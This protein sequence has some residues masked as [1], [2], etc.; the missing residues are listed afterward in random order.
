MQNIKQHLNKIYCMDSLEF[1]KTLPD[2]CVDLVLTDPPYNISQ[3]SGG[4]RE[5]D[6]GEWDKDK[7]NRLVFNAIKEIDRICNGTIIIF[8]GN[9]Q[10]SYI[11]NFLESKDYITKCLV[12]LKPNPSVIN[13]QHSFVAGQELIV[14]AKKRN[15]FFNPA[16]KL[17]Y[18]KYP[19]PSSRNHPTEKPIEL[20]KEL[21][22]D[23]SRENDIVLDCFAGSGTTLV[24]CKQLK[25][26]YIGCEISKEYCDIAEKRLS[27]NLLF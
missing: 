7:D 10:F 1:M 15:A 20:V 8:C 9:Q 12:W 27:Q 3:K 6:F 17:S 18:F 4:I 23:C 26:N 11:Y 25:R 16:F 13:C 14:Y 2:K 24:A 22:Q 19:F 21:V 5:L